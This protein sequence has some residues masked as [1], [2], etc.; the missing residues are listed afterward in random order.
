MTNTALLQH[1]MKTIITSGGALP[2]KLQ[3]AQHHFSLTEDDVVLATD[4][5]SI[6]ERLNVYTSGYVLR[7]LDCMYADF[8]V[9][10]KFLGEDLFDHFAKAYLAF[11][12]ST[13]FSLYDLCAGF[14]AF[15]ERTKPTAQVAEEQQ[16]FLDLPIAL[17]MLERTVH[18]VLRIAGTEERISFQEDLSVEM[19]LFQPLTIQ[20]NPCLRLLELS[21]PVLPF[22]HAIQREEEYDLPEP[23]QSFVAV[24]R[25]NYRL[26]AEP[27]QEWQFHFLRTCTAAISLTE[28]T[29][30]AAS[31][32]G[33][34][35]SALLAELYIW[36]PV[37]LHNGS[38]SL[39]AD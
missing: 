18:E 7:L 13:S 36:L 32:T 10:R 8:P 39:M 4:K 3:K 22:Y 15:L 19:M 35:A 30:I 34:D 33:L 38:I 2:Y 23:K 9:L 20:A 1:W 27:I 25:K 14:P 37:L 16:A 24:C 17:A 11:H 28:A 12:P 29:Q 21:F 5:A 26:H 31:K 6:H